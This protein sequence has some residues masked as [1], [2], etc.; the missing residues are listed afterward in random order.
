MECAGQPP[1]HVRSNCLSS[2]GAWQQVL[3]QAAPCQ[4]QLHSWMGVVLRSPSPPSLLPL[5]LV[6]CTLCYPAVLSNAL[7]VVRFHFGV[8][9]AHYS[10]SLQEGSKQ[11]MVFAPGASLQGSTVDGKV[12]FKG[13]ANQAGAVAVDVPLCNSVLH[14][15]DTVLLP[16]DREQMLA[17]GASKTEGATAEL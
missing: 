1:A 7:Q 17:K 2:P 14:V 4:Q 10:Q 5:L 12:T 13:P 3:A 6:L 9:G 15:V 8:G 11:I 16:E